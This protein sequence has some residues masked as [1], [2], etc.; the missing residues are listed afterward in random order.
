MCRFCLDPGV[1]LLTYK[2]QLGNLNTNWIWDEIKESLVILLG[3]III[4]KKI[5]LFYRDAHLNMK[6]GNVTSVIYFKTIQQNINWNKYGK[7]LIIVQSGW[8]ALGA[9]YGI[10]STVLYIW[11]FL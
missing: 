7:L 11:K 6:G 5:S 9:H 1:N 4:C 2:W 10:F 3:M 8:R